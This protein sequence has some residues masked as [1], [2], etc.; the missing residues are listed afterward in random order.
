MPKYTFACEHGHTVKK[1]TSSK[2]ETLPCTSCTS[3][4][5]RQLPTLG[6]PADVTETVDKYMNVKWRPDQKEQVK[7]RRD[8]FYWTVEVPRMVGSGVYSV[9]TMLENGWITLDDHHHVIIN[10]KPPDKR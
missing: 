8:E 10:N 1:F 2:V 9:E 5:T 6:G 4:M 3:T 7:Q